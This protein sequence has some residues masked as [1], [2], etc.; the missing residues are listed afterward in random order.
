MSNQ[1]LA[2]KL[3]YYRQ[4][5]GYS[6]EE[7]STKTSVTVRTI[8]RIEKAEVNPHL[9]TVK[10]LAVALEVH[11]DDLLQLE[12]PRHETIKKK[13]LLL[14]HATPL[15][16]IFLPLFNVL[17]PLFIWIHKR[18]DN[19]IYDLHGRKVV[20]FQITVCILAIFSFISLLTLEKWGFIIFVTA[21]PI[22]IIIILLNI[23]YVLQKEVCFY[24]LSI[25][26]LKIKR[27]TILKSVILFLMF[28]TYLDSIAQVDE[29]ER[30]DGSTITKTEL[31]IK[32]GELVDS[33]N[34][35]G[36]AV[37]IIRKDSVMYQKAFGYSNVEE[38]K[39]LNVNDVFYGASLSKAVF[40]YIV[41]KL[42][43][44]E[45]ID[46]D[47]P[48]QSY[49]EVSIPELHF[50][51]EWRNFKNVEDD[52][53]Y[54]ELTARMCLS[55]T[56][57]LPNW[58]WLSRTGEFQPEGKIQ[59]YTDPGLK[60]SYSGEG[61]RLLQKVLEKKLGIGLEQLAKEYV[62][63]P[64]DMRMTSYVWQK[65]FDD[66]YCYGHSKSQE[67]IKK[68]IED[69]AGAAGSMETTPRDYAKFLKK[70]LQLSHEHSKVTKIMFEP[71][72]KINSKKQ[73]GPGALEIT[74]A[75]EQIDLSY[76]LGWGILT[77][78]YGKGYFKE[79]HSEGFQHYSIIFPEKDLAIL[80][81]GNS[82]NAESIFKKLLEIGISDIYTPWY[83]EDY[84]PYNH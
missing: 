18:E 60:Y 43:I 79:G 6:Q 84:I 77:S 83:W 72:I 54:K 29:I 16:G 71:A 19:P 55:H 42:V 14:L 67:V 63:N 17:I 53:R 35:T 30:L 75:N 20:N 37:T 8:Q 5:Q 69:E 32:I 46:L 66:N 50:K 26:F 24:P 61:I 73:F 36:L 33:A 12:N 49:L 9:N 44:D 62:F 82:D 59:F 74:D 45:R 38:K 34:V 10:L 4:L 27:H 40:G 15:L 48:L 78:P 31:D 76:G 56:T 81:M 3:K 1:S 21:I 68:D 64:L 39:K 22:C 47:V 51:R 52:I 80:L 11:V 70:I 65:R 57:G 23:F 13:W 2:D 7:L 28:F 58:R 25:P 41:A